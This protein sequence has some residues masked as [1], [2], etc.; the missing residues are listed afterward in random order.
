[1][2]TEG[3]PGRGHILETVEKIR[4]GSVVLNLP[5]SSSHSKEKVHTS[6][7]RSGLL[8]SMQTHSEGP[9]QTQSSLWKG[10]EGGVGCDSLTALPGV[11]P[12]GM[13]K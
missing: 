3:V 2:V 8:A 1:M 12:N 10:A 4:S 9:S 13:S 7:E 5:G 6:V 11:F